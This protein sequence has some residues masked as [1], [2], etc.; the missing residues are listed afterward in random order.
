MEGVIL[1]P[2]GNVIYFN[3]P[4]IMERKDMD[5]ATDVALKCLN[6]ILPATK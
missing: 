3:P 5:F 1:R 4:L 2:L 6:E